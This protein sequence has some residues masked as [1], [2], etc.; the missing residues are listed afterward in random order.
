[1]KKRKKKEENEREKKTTRQCFMIELKKTKKTHL[2]FGL[3]HQ[4]IDSIRYAIDTV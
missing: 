1:M 2:D 4:S 3:S